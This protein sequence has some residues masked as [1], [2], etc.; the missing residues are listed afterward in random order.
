MKTALLCL[1]L[2]A[3]M[4]GCAAWHSCGTNGTVDEDPNPDYPP[5]HCG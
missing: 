4:T 1:F 3:P 5:P 2:I